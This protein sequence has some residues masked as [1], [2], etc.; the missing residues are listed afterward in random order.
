MRAT[1]D[2]R[3]EEILLQDGELCSL[4]GRRTFVMF[5]H[6]LILDIAAAGFIEFIESSK[7]TMMR[8]STRKLAQVGSEKS[9]EGK[10]SKAQK[11]QHPQTSLVTQIRNVLSNNGTKEGIVFVL[12]SPKDQKCENCK[13]TKITGRRT[14]ESTPR[15]EKFGDLMTADHEVLNEG[16]ESRNNHSKCSIC[17]DHPLMCTSA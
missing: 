6:K 12:T 15:A 13:R 2:Q 11:C 1:S 9:L 10:I 17:S 8:W 16:C 14:G 7:N 5:Q 3:W 4:F